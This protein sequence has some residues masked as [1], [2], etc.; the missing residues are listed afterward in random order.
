MNLRIKFV[1]FFF[2][3]FGG[4]SGVDLRVKFV[5]NLTSGLIKNKI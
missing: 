1:L 3:G 5:R 2:K 4:D